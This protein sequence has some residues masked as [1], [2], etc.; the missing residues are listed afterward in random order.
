MRRPDRAGAQD[1]LARAAHLVLR[2]VAVRAKGHADGTSAL[3]ENAGD[4]RVGHDGE[5]RP[6]ARRRVVAVEDAEAASAALRHGDEAGALV[7]LAVEICGEWDSDTLRRVDERLGEDVPVGEVGERKRSGRAACEGGLDVV[8]RPTRAPGCRPAVVVGAVSPQN[9][10]RVH[11]GGAAEH[12]PPREHDLAPVER[13]LRRRRVAPVDLRAIELRE[14]CRDPHVELARSPPGL[15]EQNREVRVLRETRG[16]DAAR[17][18]TADDHDVVHAPRIG[19]DALGTKPC[20]TR[21]GL[22]A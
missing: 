17:R 22:R 7:V 18:S 10:H 11:R 6:P 5:V 8:P 4:E 9:H 2:L 3:D 13:R 14:G 12:A 20:P 19:R 1:D 16:E 15:D 21:D